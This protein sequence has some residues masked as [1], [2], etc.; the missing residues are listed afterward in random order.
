MSGDVDYPTFLSLLQSTVSKFANRPA[1]LMA[2]RDVS[3]GELWEMAMTQSQRWVEEGIPA[4]QR[5]AIQGRK[6]LE[7]Y[8][9]IVA[10]WINGCCHVPLNGRWPQEHR[11]QV[12]VL[13]ETWTAGAAAKPPRSTV[14]DLA[15][16][17]CT[18]GS[19]GRPKAVAITQ[20]QFG[21][22]AQ[23]LAGI[24]QL[25]ESDR[26]LHTADLSFDMS[27]MEL[28]ATWTVG[29]ALCVV[30]PEHALMAPRFVDD[31]NL[32][33][34][35]SVPSA[36]TLSQRA[37]LLSPRSM[38]TVRLGVLGGEALTGATASLLQQA[39]PNARLMNFWGP[40]E[41]T[42]SLTHFELPGQWPGDDLVPIGRAHDGVDLRLV[43]SAVDASVNV[44][45]S[46]ELWASG[47][48]VIR[49]YWTD[50][51]ALAGRFVE[52]GGRVW[53]R[54]GDC[55][56]WDPSTGYRF[57]GRIDRQFKHKGYRI[58]PGDIESAMRRVLGGDVVC[59]V[60]YQAADVE[61]GV[62]RILAY[63]E[64]AGCVFDLEA[65]GAQLAL[66]LPSYMLPADIRS[67]PKFPRSTAG[68]I[69]HR[70]LQADAI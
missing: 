23:V 67:L 21:R 56:L 26:V 59:G 9:H 51:V 61:H 22:Y 2:E 28:A 1:L 52:D 33:V 20:R 34:W 12:A 63:V 6:T 65:L 43:P 4:G 48:Q 17:I 50:E 40:T 64:E 58:E 5:M 53:Y 19:T 55:A 68:K 54:T 69:D 44:S 25:N 45:L 24:L 60:I 66:L 38:P 29:A 18:S 14:E 16:L 70:R 30:R 41:G 49:N 36:L 62:G 27:M 8:V 10:L 42:V 11:R 15:Y 3:Y 37:G 32:T 13:G 57:V 47:T 31:R 39:A 46:G 35:F 7:E